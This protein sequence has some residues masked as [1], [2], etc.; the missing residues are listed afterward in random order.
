[1]QKFLRHCRR[2]VPSWW[3]ASSI[4]AAPFSAAGQ[5][6]ATVNVTVNQPGALVSS[7]LF[8]IFFE[9]INYAGEGGLYAEM[10]RNRAFYDPST[11]YYWDLVTS[12]SAT[13]SMV[14]DATMPLNTNLLNS[15]KLTF[16][17]G[18][19]S[20]GAAN[21]GFWGMS[22]QAGATYNLS[23][24]ART[25]NRFAGA[26]MARLENAAGTTNYAE[27]SFSGLTTNWQ[28][29]TASFVSTATDT[30]AQLVLSMAQSGTLWLD[31]VSLF[32]QATFDER[33][34]G[35]ESRL[36][37]LLAANQPSFL[38]FPGGNFIE[39]DSITNSVRWK[40]TLG[41]IAQRPGH[42]NDAWGY[43]S[44]DGYGVDE[45]FRQCEDLHMVPLYAINAGLALG[46]DG[47]TNN[48]VPLADMGP[49]VQDALDLIEYANGDTNTT[50]GALR[51][52]NGHPAP[53]N[54]QY[55]E[56]GN[57]NGGTYYDARYALFYNAIKSNYPAMHLIVP[58]WG[59]VPSSTPVEIQDEHYYSS[60][61]TFISYATKYDSYSRTGPKVFVGEYAVTSGYGTYGNLAAALGEASFMTGMERNSDLVLM[62]S[63]APLFGNVNSMQWQPDLIYFNSSQA[64][65]TPSYYVQQM[66]SR[67]RGDFVLPT[68][69]T[70]TTN[71][72]SYTA[73][74]TIGLGSWNTA[75]QYTNI[76]VTSNGVTLYKSDFT[77]QG[78]N[79]WSVDNGT[80]SATNGVYQ[81][82]AE[83][84]DCYATLLTNNSTSWANYTLSLQARK[85]GGSEGFLIMFNVLDSAD[86]T[87][88]NIG[89]WNNTLDGIEQM[90]S[91]S[92]T[93][94]AQVAQTI[95]SDTWYYIRVVVTG[96][97]A[98][99]YLGTNAVQAA[100][101]LVQDVTLPTPS[102]GLLV[103]STYSRAAS[104]V[105]LKAVNPYST[106]L[107]TT[108]HLNGVDSIAANA[109]LIQLTSASA[110][111]ENSFSAPT[112]VSPVTNTVA[113][114]GTNFTLTLPANSLSILRLTA[115]GVDDYTNLV[116]EIPSP[117]T[118][119]V[120]VTA[121]L[122]A[123]KDG[124]WTD[125]DTSSGS[126]IV[127]SSANTN[128]ATVDAYG[129]VTGQANGTTRIV[130]TY[131]ALGLSA[132][133]SVQVVAV[134]AV[135]AHR[136]SF[137][138]TNGSTTVADSIGGAAWS[139]TLPNG[140]TFSGSNVTFSAAGEQ[141]FN[142]PGGILSNYPS[143]TIELWAPAL[144]G[145]ATSPPFVYLFAFGNT[146]AS[147]AGY[148]YV[149]FNPNLAR[150]VIS[151][152]D[153]G[154]GD[155]QGGDLSASLGTATNLHLTC[156]FDCSGGEI[157]V[158]TN[159]VLAS[160]FAG[161]T[162]PLSDVGSEFA[163]VGRSLYTADS[164]LTWSLQEL[165]IYAGVL[166]PAEVAA[167][168]A[169]GPNQLLSW[170]NPMVTSSV[171]SNG[172]TLSWPLASAGYTVLSTTNLA[173]PVWSESFVTLRQVGNTWQVNLPITNQ[174]QFFQLVK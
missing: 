135:L 120:A 143:A 14:V 47:S 96:L 60:P 50:W 172:L 56:I 55:M 128:I 104:Q 15:L 107:T 133:Q 111:D 7:N 49:W 91:G 46:Y 117:I 147:G 130:A 16:S 110:M 77:G 25:T 136:Y 86:W 145:A 8:G 39:G 74:G 70:V 67:N 26:L 105:I 92:K 90:V 44:T 141:Y 33:T 72:S 76:I 9:E 62:A 166:A 148:D 31:V 171:S 139:G 118:N 18:S 28:K 159:G 167:T 156:V 58:D 22:V 3:M 116:L 108:F 43:W 89:G 59:G 23:L 132:T 1:M 78:T 155:E 11:P 52:A 164:Y 82:T 115:A 65:G 125:L 122:L 94:Y 51:A 79:G 17:S 165:R 151:A 146:D 173:A 57:E 40:K 13:G 87:W 54:L 100:T 80:W 106:A 121:T 64:F 30:N 53:Y 38:R 124:V 152:V 160:T 126:I 140:G 153:P 6:T 61:A 162:D 142:L 174:Q 95:S 48:T 41:D 158:Y 19:G 131:P 97:R 5:A 123:G 27:A 88:W 169:L 63:Y 42:L 170:T 129:D 69:V 75:V 103:S 45:F 34:N 127:W 119:G 93:A 149:F 84:T 157:L 71:S 2:V 32:P 68:A 98:Q 109:S 150:T 21:A 24:Y 113:T 99:C 66:F 137:N 138:G 37:G 4:L 168:Q 163:Y 161:I 35:L 36:A 112:Y 20:V 144:A 154:Y 85:T 101:N 10:V 83:I 81:Q 102:G 134:P 29:F 114:A 12:G 73:R